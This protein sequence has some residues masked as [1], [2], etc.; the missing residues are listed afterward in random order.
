MTNDTQKTAEPAEIVEERTGAACCPHPKWHHGLP[1]VNTKKGYCASCP[2]DRTWHD[3]EDV[4]GKRSKGVK[5]LQVAD[6]DER[7][8]K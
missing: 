8:T 7:W 3:Y 5:L 4:A 6:G 1:G 2:S